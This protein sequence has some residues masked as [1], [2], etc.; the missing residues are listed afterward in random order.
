MLPRLLPLLPTLIG[1][2]AMFFGDMREKSYV[3]LMPSM[4]LYGP[5]LLFA[6]ASAA[7]GISSDDLLLMP[8]LPLTSYV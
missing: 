4:G 3:F 6:C 2:A 7:V 8:T 1:V 5:R